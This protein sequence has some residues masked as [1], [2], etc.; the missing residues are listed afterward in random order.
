MRLANA[1]RYL[2]HGPFDVSTEAGRSAERYRLALL[3]VLANLVGRGTGMAAMVLG[4]SWTIPYLGVERFGV[5]VTISS[6]SAML[7][8]LDLGTGNAL[9]NRVARCAAQEDAT[10]IRYAISGGL[11][12]LALA[13][14]VISML[15]FGLA[16]VLPWHTLLK[17]TDPTVTVEARHAAMCFGVMF[18][19][20]IFTSGIQKV[21]AGLQRAFEAHATSA[22][23]ALIAIGAL[24]VA[25]SRQVSVPV[26]LLVTLGAQSAAALCLL[27]VL[28]RR[29]QLSWPDMRLQTLAEARKLLK[30]GTLFLVLQ[31]GVM[32]G[33]GADSLII[34]SLLGVA[35]VAIYGLAQR[36]LQFVSI[37]LSMIN[38]PLWAAYADAQARNDADFMRRTLVRS[39]VAT[40]TLAIIGVGVAAVVADTVV[41][42]WAH[43]QVTIPKS[44]LLLFCLWT[45]LEA[46]GNAFA[47][48]LNGCGVIRPQ[49]VSVLAFCLL[50]IPL[51]FY[52]GR[53]F[54]VS[55]V[56]AASVGAYLIAVPLL[57]STLFRTTIAE[58]LRTASHERLREAAL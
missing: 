20:N 14:A 56:L 32:I 15:L 5:W 8:F 34:S 43:G 42:H 44:V 36:L 24:W 40:G 4:V 17:A 25:T 45:V 9:T 30:V 49:V 50:A 33:W 58:T 3:S 1:L 39:L 18:G 57:Y 37:P 47:M 21:F 51:K 38:S 26:L 29:R 28:A 23:G 13:G 55:G 46:T 6:F 2:R 53:A 31:I 27:A 35:Q 19:L 7:A 41:T 12:F 10:K 54:G 22:V 16:A 52:L 11:G 48:F